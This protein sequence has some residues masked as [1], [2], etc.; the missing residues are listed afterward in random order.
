[1][2][3]QNNF[4]IIFLIISFFLQNTTFSQTKITISSGV[5]ASPLPFATIVNSTNKTFYTA[6]EFGQIML[7]AN[8]YDSLIVS[9]VGYNTNS[10]VFLIADTVI[11]LYPKLNNLPIVN[12][13]PC[14]TFA[15]QYVN[16]YDSSK[17]DNSFSGYNIGEYNNYN[18]GKFAMLIKS[19]IPN[20]Y[21]NKI[22]FWLNEIFFAPKKAIQN[23]LS[24]FFYKVIETTLKPGDAILNN[25]IIIYPKRA[26]SQT[27]NFDS[28]H[29]KIPEQGIYISFQYLP[30]KKFM[31]EH[32]HTIDADSVK[33]KKTRFGGVIA[34]VRSK[35]TYIS[36]YN[37]IKD[38]WTIPK[39]TTGQVKYEIKL[40]YCKQ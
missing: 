14:I 12:I 40:K 13:I 26:G 29:I 3:F 11:K 25:P 5:D 17:N 21:L 2:K 1:M 35:P 30:D 6:D 38:S 27:I 15:Y 37:V 19:P 16:N 39:I 32:T 23:P 28:V 9:Y 33:I 20:A 18:S 34:G 10:Y 31:W 24:V 36:F 8:L 22:T 7:Q 4:V